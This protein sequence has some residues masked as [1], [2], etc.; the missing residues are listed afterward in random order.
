M[1]YQLALTECKSFFKPIR[2]EN[3]IGL[4]KIETAAGTTIAD[5]ALSIRSCFDFVQLDNYR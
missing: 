4:G 1:D 5:K 3:L 2:F